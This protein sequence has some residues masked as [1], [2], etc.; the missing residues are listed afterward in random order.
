M[1]HGGF[2]VD[3]IKQVAKDILAALKTLHECKIGKHNV[4]HSDIKPNNIAMSVSKKALIL[5]M[6]KLLDSKK[7]LAPLRM[8]CQKT[9]INGN[10]IRRKMKGWVPSGATST[11]ASDAPKFKLIDLGNCMVSLL[12]VKLV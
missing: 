10:A 3:V 4:A 12:A 6:E 11:E 8:T 2:A 1:K 9:P 7:D 5:Q